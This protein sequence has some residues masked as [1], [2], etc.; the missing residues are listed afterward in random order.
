MYSFSFGGVSFAVFREGKEICG[1]FEIISFRSNNIGEFTD[2][3][4]RMKCT[5][6]IINEI[7]VVGD[8]IIL[9]KA[10]LKTHAIKNYTLNELLCKICK[11]A[12]CFDE[13]EFTHYL[14]NLTSELMQLQLLQVGLKEGV[15]KWDL[16]STWK[17]CFSVPLELPWASPGFFELPYAFLELPWCLLS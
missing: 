11:L 10:A 4:K 14:E 7:E 5:K 1:G 15:L 3:L 12:M 6:L 8:C 2:C 17:L 13:I 9:T 16:L